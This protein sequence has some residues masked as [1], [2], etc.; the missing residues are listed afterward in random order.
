MEASMFGACANR[1]QAQASREGSI[2]LGVARCQGWSSSFCGGG[3]LL[4]VCEEIA[5]MD[6]RRLL[7]CCLVVVARVPRGATRD[8]P[9]VVAESGVASAS[10]EQARPVC[11]T[12]GCACHSIHTTLARMAR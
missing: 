2:S 3:H 9:R 8:G 4:N 5:S 11:V 12:R 10:N 7:V 1:H 6:C